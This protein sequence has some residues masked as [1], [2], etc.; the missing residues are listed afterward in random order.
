MDDLMRELKTYFERTKKIPDLEI[1]ELP[2]G[3]SYRPNDKENADPDGY[4]FISDIHEFLNLESEW[5]QPKTGVGHPDPIHTDRMITAVEF[6]SWDEEIIFGRHTPEQGY[7]FSKITVDRKP[8]G[9][10]SILHQYGKKARKANDFRYF[11][12]RFNP[13]EKIR[14]DLYHF[15]YL[16]DE[17]KYVRVALENP[18]SVEQKQLKAAFEARIDEAEEMKRIAGKIMFRFRKEYREFY[19]RTERSE[20]VVYSFNPKVVVEAYGTMKVSDAIDRLK[21]WQAFLDSAEAYTDALMLLRLITKKENE[22][23]YHHIQKTKAAVEKAITHAETLNDELLNEKQGPVQEAVDLMRMLLQPR[24]ESFTE[25]KEIARDYLHSKL[26]KE[27]NER[28][29]Y[30]NG[31]LKIMNNSFYPSLGEFIRSIE[32][33]DQHADERSERKIQQDI[34]I[35]LD[36][37]K[38]QRAIERRIKQ[39][40][41]R[42]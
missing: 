33:Y 13:N 2:A 24:K 8:L 31:Y 21:K 30:F 20:G 10:V 32:K 6:P 18:K 15:L 22:F 4:I 11:D 36:E 39:G 37:M 16:E 29:A 5:V 12:E 25:G 38:R 40:N 28:L 9:V 23:I 14:Q 42:T 19:P 34:L 27:Y 17:G 26:K 3:K 41:P 35:F 1:I 7:K